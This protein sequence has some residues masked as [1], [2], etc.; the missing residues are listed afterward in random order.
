MTNPYI[1]GFLKIEEARKRGS[2]NI[3]TEAKRLDPVGKED[4]DI[5]NDGVKGDSDRYLKNRRAVIS[6]AVE[7][8]TLP[9][10]ELVEMIAD[11]VSEKMIYEGSVIKLLDRTADSART[12]AK[13]KP[14]TDADILTG[15]MPPA[16]TQDIDI[17][18]DVDAAGA[19][20]QAQQDIKD[21]EARVDIAKDV[22]AAGAKRQAQQDIKDAEARAISPP[23]RVTPIKSPEAPKVDAGSGT[24]GLGLALAGRAVMDTTDPSES[25]GKPKDDAIPNFDKT[26]DAAPKLKDDG[27]VQDGIVSDD[28][29]FGQAFRAAR[30]AAEAAGHKASGRFTWKGNE[31]QTNIKGEKFVPYSRQTAVGEETITPTERQLIESVLRGTING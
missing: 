12:V 4:G 18:K 10:D 15:M 9:I 1:E 3:F 27:T 16:K 23:E 14:K 11:Y 29:S 22:D 19:K 26:V 28:M 13:T 25:P 24:L 17:A 8:N 21:A 2:G 31:Y 30:K 5:D 20:R 6:K 7:E